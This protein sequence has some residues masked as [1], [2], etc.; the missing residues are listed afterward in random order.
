MACTFSE[1]LK[2]RTII[3]ESKEGLSVEIIAVDCN[4]KNLPLK[5]QMALD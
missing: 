4:S 1:T 2:T 5:F 3:F